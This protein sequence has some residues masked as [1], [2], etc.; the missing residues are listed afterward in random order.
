MKFNRIYFNNNC[1]KLYIE[2][3]CDLEYSFLSYFIIFVIN[4]IYIYIF[5]YSSLR[6]RL[7]TNNI[8]LFLQT[9]GIEVRVTNE[10][11]PSATEETVIK[12]AAH[13]WTTMSVL[14]SRTTPTTPTNNYPQYLSPHVFQGRN[15]LG[16]TN[17]KVFS[18]IINIFCIV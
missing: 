15:S 5:I 10:V 3:S 8:L 14:N 17:G 16:C 6:E 13:L 12:D 9:V 11:L 4:E 7:I 1:S 2:L 18:L